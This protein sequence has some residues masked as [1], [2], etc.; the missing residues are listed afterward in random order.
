MPLVVGLLPL[1][2]LGFLAHATVEWGL[3]GLSAFLGVTSLCLG[4]RQHRSRRALAV[5]GIGL[6]LLVLGRILEEWRVGWYGV[7]ILVLGG[8]TIAA[9]HLFNR[10]LCRTCYACNAKAERANG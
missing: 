4:Y 10:H 1:V 6:A 9:A 7:P 8:L 3:I 2:G 5:L